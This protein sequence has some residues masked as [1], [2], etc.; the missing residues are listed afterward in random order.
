M[1]SNLILVMSLA[2]QLCSHGGGPLIGVRGVAKENSQCVI[3][4]SSA[5]M[6]RQDGVYSQFKLL[7][8]IGSEL[9]FYP[10]IIINSLARGPPAKLVSN[11]NCA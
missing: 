11:T 1:R 7:P 8:Q 9:P 4:S 2:R 10:P 5:D 3:L 6:C